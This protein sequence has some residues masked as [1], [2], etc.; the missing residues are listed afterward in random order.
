MNVRRYE[1]PS[2]NTLL[3]FEATA[4]LGNMSLAAAERRTSQSAIS[5]H[6]R[7]LETAMGVTLFRRSGRSVALTETGKTYLV[8]VQS[9]MEALHAVERRLREEKPGLTLGCTL[10][11]SGLVLLPVFSR[12]K[13]ALGD[14]VAI[15]VVTYDYD[16]LQLLRPAG[17]DIVFE[18]LTRGPPS[19]DAVKVLDEQIVPV[20]SPALLERYG[21][22]LARHPRHW[23]GVPRLDIGRR[24]PGWA[25]WGTW[26]GA[27]DCAAPDVP[28]ETFENYLYLL[29]AA[30]EGDG[31]A[32]G[33]NGFMADYVEAGRLVAVREQWLNTQL[34]MYAVLT[35]AGKTSRASRACQKE[36]AALVGEVCTP[37][38][39]GAA[40]EP[41]RTPL[42][43]IEGRPPSIVRDAGMQRGQ[44]E[45]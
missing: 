45:T 37:A 1:I 35:P 33:W 29:R 8:T 34:T 39:P 2:I 17:L 21:K 26:F 32:I 43:V 10:E 19:T 38:P 42:Q 44:D 11:I 16:M 14:E 22:V 5:R 6:I 18:A 12:L 9:S 4:R 13:R 40:A 25:T 36:L 24:S 30:A 41:T 31:I 23:S 20:A 15:R 27:H 3:A 7:K 28:V